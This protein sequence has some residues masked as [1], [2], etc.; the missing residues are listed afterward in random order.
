M[1]GGI[2]K[3]GSEKRDVLLITCGKEKTFRMEAHWREAE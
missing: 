2:V 3:H 1:M